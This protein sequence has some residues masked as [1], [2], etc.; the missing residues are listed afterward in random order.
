MIR[1]G[2]SQAIWF[3]SGC[4]SLFLE[5]GKVGDLRFGAGLSHMSDKLFEESIVPSR[6]LEFSFERAFVGVRLDH[7]EGDFSQQARF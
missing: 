2:N 6:A 7:V 5:R 3:G 1:P 4:D